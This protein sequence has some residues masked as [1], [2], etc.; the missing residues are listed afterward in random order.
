M[1]NAKHKQME[2]KVI[3]VDYSK[4]VFHKN[5]TVDSKQGEVE[6]VEI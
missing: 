6:E 5:L 3:T 2:K 4:G 1:Q